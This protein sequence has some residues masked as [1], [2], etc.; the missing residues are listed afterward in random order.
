M[1]EVLKQILELEDQINTLSKEHDNTLNASDEEIKESQAACFRA[2]CF[3][4][5]K[6]REKLIDLYRDFA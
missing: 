1:I 3:L 2:I 6:Q 5:G 4:K